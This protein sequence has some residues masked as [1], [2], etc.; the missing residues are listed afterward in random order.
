MPLCYL[1][2]RNPAASLNKRRM[3]TS[4]RTTGR[5]YHAF[6]G[7]TIL[8]LLVVV[9]IIG[10]LA[11][12]VLPALHRAQAKAHGVSCLNNLKQLQMGWQMYVDD[13]GG[14]VPLNYADL[15]T[16][17]WRSSSNSW[18]GPSSAPFDP[19]DSAIRQSSLFR[20]GYVQSPATFVC[21]GDD[22]TVSRRD[23][24]SAGLPRSRSYAMNGNFGGR[25]QEAQ[26]VFWR[27]NLSYDPTKVFVF[28]DEHEDSIDDAHFLTWPNP[29]DRW[30][31]LP[32]GRHNRSGTLSFADGHAENWKWKWRKQ[33]G[34]KESY[35]KRAENEA[36]LADLRR[37]QE[38]IL[39][40]SGN[41]RPQP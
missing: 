32:A 38:H 15:S 7:L 4:T 29:D 9:S 31:N 26:L 34:K 3:T 12:M 22:A 37:L 2:T 35:W 25:G 6:S 40:V 5:Q 41:Y 19:D 10:L 36:D 1:F 20:L 23:G 33:F 11:A 18:A 30:V 39:Q 24:K 14:K 27:E 21:P 8:E 28:I 16:G 17:V 13:H